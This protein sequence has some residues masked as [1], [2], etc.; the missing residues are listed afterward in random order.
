MIHHQHMHQ[1]IQRMHQRIQRAHDASTIAYAYNFRESHEFHVYSFMVL[2][3][4]PYSL[5]RVEKHATNIK[6]FIRK[7][8]MELLNHQ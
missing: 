5:Y 2:M 1:R 7:S 6:I 4:N 8:L 3:V